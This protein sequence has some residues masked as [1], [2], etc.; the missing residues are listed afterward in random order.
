[1]NNWREAAGAATVSSRYDVAID[2]IATRV[3][4]CSSD[5]VLKGRYIQ[6]SNDGMGREVEDAAAVFRE[7]PALDRNHVP[8]L[9]ELGWLHLSVFDDPEEAKQS[10]DRAIELTKQNTLE[11][12]HGAAE[13]AEEVGG[14]DARAEIGRLII[15]DNGERI[16]RPPCGQ[17]VTPHQ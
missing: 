10:F 1:M 15:A 11:A 5:L 16:G 13:C 9:V 14:A 6:L 17:L 4:L 12:F 3:G 7:A 8:V 2:I